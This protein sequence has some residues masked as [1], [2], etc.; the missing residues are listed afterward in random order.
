M[1]CVF[2]LISAL[3]K[4]TIGLSFSVLMGFFGLRI[5]HL[6]EVVYPLNQLLYAHARLEYVRQNKERTLT[7]TRRTGVN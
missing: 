7:C 3:L 5:R 1:F 4:P 2:L 6:Y